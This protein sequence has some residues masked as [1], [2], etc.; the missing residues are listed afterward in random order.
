MPATYEPIATTTLGSS[1]STVTFSS[2]PGTYTDLILIG[3]YSSAAATS[4]VINFNGDSGS[5]Y[6]YTYLAG[7]GGGSGSGRN[8]NATNTGISYETTAN[9]RVSVI[10]NLNNYSNS[11][12]Y[13]TILV[14]SNPTATQVNASAN[15]WRSTSAITSFV[16]TSLSGNFNSGSVFTIYGIKAA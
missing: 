7:S 3:D 14:R 8:S 13:K 6:S 16:L 9:A 2:I 11:T 4:V 10:V 1:S 5:N 12:T 15:L